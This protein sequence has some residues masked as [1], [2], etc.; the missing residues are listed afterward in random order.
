MTDAPALRVSQIELHVILVN[1]HDAP[2]RADPLIFEGNDAGSA[3]EHL[4]AW[5]ANLPTHL[6]QAGNLA[7]E[8]ATPEPEAS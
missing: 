8:D 5:L 2:V 4:S 7:P 1:E 3:A 6:A